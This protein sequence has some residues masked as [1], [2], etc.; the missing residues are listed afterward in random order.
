MHKTLKD[1]FSFLRD[2]GKLSNK[3]VQNTH[4]GQIKFVCGSSD[5]RCYL[6]TKAARLC[7]FCSSAIH[8]SEIRNVGGDILAFSFSCLF[9]RSVGNKFTNNVFS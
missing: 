3:Y 4:W 6:R 9:S 1:C 8:S 5:E 7:P 2:L